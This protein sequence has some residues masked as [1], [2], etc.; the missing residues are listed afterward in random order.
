MA[1]T[2]SA[3]QTPRPGLRITPEVVMAS[4]YMRAVTSSSEPCTAR[5]VAARP[6][7]HRHRTRPGLRVP[8]GAAG[9]RLSHI[10]SCG[11]GRARAGLVSHLR[12]GPRRR[13][14]EGAG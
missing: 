4:D 13:G 11:A 2:T 9:H 6:A 8:P 14:P 5:H 12:P 7:G 3:P 10:R 1:V